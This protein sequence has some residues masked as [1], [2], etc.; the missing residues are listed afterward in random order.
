[1]KSIN[2]EIVTQRHLNGGQLSIVKAISS[3][4]SAQA[5]V[6]PYEEPA[7]VAANRS[8]GGSPVSRWNCLLVD[9][10]P[11]RQWP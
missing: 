11:P 3:P 6:S 2:M 7:E 5:E 1:M 9:G 8:G 4:Y 10:E